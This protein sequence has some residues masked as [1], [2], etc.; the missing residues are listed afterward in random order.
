RVQCTTRC[1]LWANSG[2]W[3]VSRAR[4]AKNDTIVIGRYFDQLGELQPASLHRFNR[5]FGRHSQFSLRASWFAKN[6][7]LVA[8]SFVPIDDCK[9]TIWFQCG[10]HSLGKPSA[11]GNTMEGIRQKNKIGR[12]SQL[13]DV[14]GV[15]RDELAIVYIAFK[16]AM[17]RHF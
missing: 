4:T 2:H 14:I 12:S 17:F 6:G 1:P 10:P 16:K 9:Q 13:R 8:R 5:F 11:V 7:R 3:E 15:T